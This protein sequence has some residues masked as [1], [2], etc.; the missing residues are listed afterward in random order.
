VPEQLHGHGQMMPVDADGAAEEGTSYIP[1]HGK[2]RITF[3]PRGF[4][5]YHT[6]NRGVVNLSAGQYNGEVGPVYIEPRHE[7][8]NHDGEISLV[9]KEFEPTLSRDAGITSVVS[10]TIAATYFQPRPIS[11]PS[12]PR[13][14]H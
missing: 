13:S 2:R 11:T 7:P 12:P 9:L 5:F 1:A 8:G 10:A 3:T 6:H 4:R 14:C